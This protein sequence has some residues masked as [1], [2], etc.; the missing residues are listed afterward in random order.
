MPRH[1]ADAAVGFWSPL[2]PQPS[3]VADQS[4]RILD[5][6]KEL[7]PV[8]AVVDENVRDSIVA[9]PGVEVLTPFELEGRELSVNL[10]QFANGHGLHRFMFDAVLHQPGLLVLND[11]SVYDFVHWVCMQGR[12]RAFAEELAYDA[13]GA[14]PAEELPMVDLGDG[15]HEIDRLTVLCSRRLVQASIL[16]LVHT[17]W[18]QELLRSRFGSD[19]RLVPMPSAAGTRRATAA[20]GVRRA[21]EGGKV[22]FGVFGTVEPRDRAVQVLRA[23][24]ELNRTRPECGLTLALRGGDPTRLDELRSEIGTASLSGEQTVRV[25]LDLDPGHLDELVA[26]CDVVI[27]LRWPSS[28]EL[29]AVVT[30]ARSAGKPLVVSDLPQLADLP[31]SCT[32]RIA[33]DPKA[34]HE[35]LLSTMAML[36]DEPQV[37]ASATEQAR[38]LAALQ[39]SAGEV[40]ARYAE[41]IADAGHL[42]PAHAVR[43]VRDLPRLGEG[44]NAVGCWRATTGIAEAARR[45]VRA[46]MSCGLA[47][48]L[49]QADVDAPLDERRYTTELRSLPSGHPFGIDLCFLNLNELDALPDSYRAEERGERLLVGANW[50]WELTRVPD[51]L[52]DRARRFGFDAV[53]VASEFERQQLEPVL[54]CPVHLVPLVVSAEPD[55]NR[56]RSDFG[57]P[58]AALVFLY[59]FDAFSGMRRKNPLGLIDA[60]RRAFGDEHFAGVH[61]VVK[62]INL[63]RLP[64]AW[65]TLRHAVARVGGT[66]IDDNMTA[67]ELASLV[68]CCDVYVSLHRSEG[69]GLGIAEAMLLGKLVIATAYSGSTQFLDSSTGCPVGYDLVPALPADQYLNPGLHV[70]ELYTTEPA[71]A[72]WAAPDVDEAARLLRWARDHPEERRARGALASERIAGR[73]DERAVGSALKELLRQLRQGAGR[74]PRRP[75]LQALA[76]SPR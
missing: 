5:E 52:V 45:S 12:H 51:K 6:L 64:E 36:V 76:N 49:E 63:Q 30:E 65:A 31:A 53:F 54:D 10:Y 57:L 42:G 60:Y 27:A 73:Y 72:F 4:F 41:L 11:P 38:T 13:C 62:A 40:A 66:L 69:F 17:A 32:W 33:T 48:A 50:A 2:P 8:V 34:E 21:G 26:G 68:A 46:A 43:F 22:L 56:G 18:A 55:P 74:R 16:T 28:G 29:S 58:D 9:P 25:E 39:P 35:Q 59:S 20:N 71:P 75:D 23:F 7:V 15:E 47:V 1:R 70:A 61:L 14:Y 44:F 67:G 19:V 24:L 3:S 37:L